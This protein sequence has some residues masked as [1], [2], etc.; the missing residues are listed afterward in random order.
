M[1]L[2]EGAT[3]AAVCE[4]LQTHTTAD[5]L[6]WPTWQ[7]TL[8]TVCEESRKQ[9]KRIGD[10]A[11][12]A[13]PRAARLPAADGADLPMMGR[14]YLRHIVE[15]V[16]Q[17]AEAAHALHEAGVIHRDVKPGN[18]MVSADGGQAVL[19]DLGLAQL[20]DDTQGRLTRT[21][22]FVGTLRYASPEQVLA[23]GGLDRRSDVY[24]LGATLWELLTLRPMFG[25]TE[26]TP[27]ARRDAAHSVRGAGT[28]AQ[29]SSGPA[30][31]PGRHRAQVPGETSRASL[32]HGRRPGGRPAPLSQRRAGARPPG[33][34]GGALLALV[35]AQPDSRGRGRAGGASR[36]GQRGAADRLAV[37]RDPPA[38]KDRTV[39][40]LNTAEEQKRLAEKYRGE[41]ERLSAQMTFNNGVDLCDAGDAGRGILWMARG[42]AVCPDSAPELRR[43]IRTAMPSAAATLHTL[44]A[45]FPYPDQNVVTAFS[46]DGKTLLFGGKGGCLVDVQTGRRRGVPLVTDVAMS[47]GAF[48]SDGK[49]FVTSDMGG[50]IRFADAST[51]EAVGSAVHHGGV[52]KSVAF[53]PDG[54]TVVVA[55][56][57][58]VSLQCYD[59]DSRRPVGPTFECKDNLYAATYSP[60]GKIVA[61]AAKENNASLWDAATG[62][63]LGQPLLHPGVVFSESF[64][65]DGKTLVTGC[66]D[67]GVRLWDVASGKPV[68]PVLR[69]KGTV[70]SAVFSR[71]GRLVLTS[72]E[73]G[74]ARLWEAAAGRPV[75]QQLSHSS[76]LRNA[77]FS[78]DQNY[79]LTA[80]FEGTARLW[81][82]ASEQ[83][84]AKVLP[85][86]G[87]VVVASFSP[88]GKQVLT[89]CQESE[90]RPGESRL[91]D[92]ATGAALGP[93]MSQQGQVMAAAFSPDGKLVLTAGNDG[94]ARLWK[95]AD[96]T[97][98]QDPWK[99]D[100]V[101]AAAV[102]FS[103]DG[104]LAAIAGRG[105]TVQL[106]EVATGK[107][108]A[109]WPVADHQTWVWSLAF[110][111]D[112]RRLLTGGK[113]SRLW[114][115]PDG[116]P[117][118]RRWNTT[119]TSRRPS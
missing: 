5:A 16:R 2:V 8:S 99:Y 92:P 52:V 73:D 33:E 110:T 1:E 19:M 68:G 102:A 32:R 4:R 114:S 28:A 20:A 84:L 57:F 64:S 44:E 107:I 13:P 108:V 12:A 27:I 106:H 22:Q 82:L 43:S 100:G 66:L 61:T 23:V 85:Q 87:A 79:I 45:V 65:P 62:R 95:T 3:L 113:T 54:K 97:P 94:T 116:R 81:R 18:I 50:A 105:R 89:G 10:D 31:R 83:A 63:R 111:P 86:P 11:P 115:V 58:G 88:D 90:G 29:V 6:D 37:R 49:L 9:E 109:A 40:A 69:H 80:G 56:Q 93:A 103:P 14:S 104:R 21:R 46:P 91:W 72:S 117:S 53:S 70:H 74:T 15:L 78:P 38:Q 119:M 24:S 98:A 39:T 30:A 47:G 77:V 112:G 75:G 17:A 34:Q 25:A 41:A 35:P 76:E 60:N 55:A 118:G 26:Q 51:G 7:A 67:G 59:V 71:D 101:A 96:G 42:L 48:R 36:P